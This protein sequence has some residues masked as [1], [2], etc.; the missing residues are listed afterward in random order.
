MAFLFLFFSCA[1]TVAAQLRKNYF[2][3]TN[4]LVF[5]NLP[6][7]SIFSSVLLICDNST[8]SSMFLLGARLFA[9][10]K[11]YL[12]A[13]RFIKH[14][15]ELHPSCLEW[16]DL[17]QEN[18]RFARIV[19]SK[20]TKEELLQAK[21]I[22]EKRINSLSELK[23][24]QVVQVSQPDLVWDSSPRLLSAF[25]SQKSLSSCSLLA[26]LLNNELMK[27]TVLQASFDD[28]F[29]D[30]PVVSLARTLCNSDRKY[31][32]MKVPSM[33]LLRELLPNQ[34]TN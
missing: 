3:C 7:I 13:F 17:E 9:E 11:C 27:N 30:S 21:E 15:W 10:Q 16:V 1:D 31:P 8:S 19:V 29:T 5:T 25:K 22:N 28:S 23:S 18:L 32:N 34:T 12:S 14:A 20:L 4:K 6:N 2:P 24:D 26:E 33:R